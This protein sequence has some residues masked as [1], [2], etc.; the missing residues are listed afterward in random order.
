[1][2]T[3]AISILV[4]AA[5]G[6]SGGG[7]G[8][9]VAAPR[10]DAKHMPPGAEGLVVGASTEAQVA[11]KLPGATVDKDKSL[12][13][14]GIVQFNDH[15]VETM[16]TDTMT[17]TLWSDGDALRLMRLILRGAGR[18]D[19]VKQ[20]IATLPDAAACRNT[21]RKPGDSGGEMLYCLATEDGARSLWVECA[22]DQQMVGGGK[23]DELTLWI[24]D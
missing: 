3:I 14:S 7:G 4:V 21:N 24:T 15:P 19:W 20:T 5:C 6:K 17:A 13:G 22:R 16:H 18:C 23:T 10:I 9:G 8:G 12:G 11:A 2:R 1:M